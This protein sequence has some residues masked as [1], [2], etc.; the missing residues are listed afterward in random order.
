MTQQTTTEINTNRYAKVIEASKRVHWEIDR[1][2]IRGRDYDRSKKFLP[3]GLSMV[4]D[5]AFLAEQE[6]HF[7]SQ[8]Q[9]RTYANMF[10][11]WEQRF[12][13]RQ[14]AGNKP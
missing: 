7:L 11:N 14:G 9:G 3:D 12:I 10:G 6:K 8:V 2:V 13:S 1:D 5:L 4:N